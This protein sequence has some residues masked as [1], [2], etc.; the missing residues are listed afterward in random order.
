MVFKIYKCSNNGD[1]PGNFE[2]FKWRYR[3]LYYE[4]NN[5]EFFDLY[6]WKFG[7][8]QLNKDNDTYGPFIY[9]NQYGII[10]LSFKKLIKYMHRKIIY[11]LS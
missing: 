4:V 8:A 9:T 5:S 10:V 1:G 7:I 11:Y 3:N 2:A 6:V